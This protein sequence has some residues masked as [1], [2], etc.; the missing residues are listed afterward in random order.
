M[1]MPGYT[2]QKTLPRALNATSS[3]A[4][5]VLPSTA[6]IVTYPIELIPNCLRCCGDRLGRSGP[7]RCHDLAQFGDMGGRRNA[8]KRGR[9]AAEEASET[10]REMTVAGKAR[11]ERDGGEI[12]AVVENGIQRMRQPFVQHVIVDRG[13]DRVAKDMAEM[14]RR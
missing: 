8:A 6:P 4:P 5:D 12:V 11:I 13:A 7:L 14:K 2:G 10:R 1:S 9:G 3:N